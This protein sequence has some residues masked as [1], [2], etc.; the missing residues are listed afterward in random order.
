MTLTNKEHNLLNQEE[1]ELKVNY[2]IENFLFTNVIN[3]YVIW[4]MYSP[5]LAEN[6]FTNF[7]K[8]F[9]MYSAKLYLSSQLMVSESY[10]K[11][12]N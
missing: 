10:V 4:L 6:F 9:I 3:L 7:Y 11:L 1:D 12:L 5:R 8:E 2:Q